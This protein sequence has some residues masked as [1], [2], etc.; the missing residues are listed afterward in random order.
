M[1]R[2]RK[3][4]IFVDLSCEHCTSTFS[5]KY[6][7]RF[8][9][10]CSVKC[11]QSSPV[12]KSLMK[13]SQLKTYREKYGVDH[14]MQSS[15]VVDNFKRSMKQKYGVEH[16][17]QD[18]TF[19]EKSKHTTEQRHG[20]SNYRNTEQMKQT[21]L[22]KYGVD[23]YV[24]TDEYKD[25][26]K[27]TCLK[28][29]GRPHA[30]QSTNFKLEHVKTMFEKILSHDRF[31]NFTPMF[32]QDEYFGILKDAS[33]VKY[34]FKCNRCNN[35]DAYN[36]NNGNPLHCVN[37]DKNNMSYFQKEVY[38]YVKSL[39]GPNVLV[40]TNN[41]TLLK[42]QELDIYIPSLNIAIECDGLYWHSEVMGAKNRVYHYNKTIH[43]ESKGVSLIHVFEN[44]WHQ[45]NEVIKSVL[46]NILGKPSFKIYA[47]NCEVKLITSNKIVES[48]L[49]NNHVQ[50]TAV[51][52][53]KIGLYHDSQLI[54]VM[55]FGKSRFDKNYEWEMVRFCNL[56]N[57]SIVGGAS[58]MFNFFIKNYNPKSI[59]S[60]NDRRYFTGKIYSKL[61]FEFVENTNPNYWYV[62]DS[63]KTLKNRMNFQKHKLKH[64]LPTFDSTLTEWE[65]MKNH[66][67]DRI[68]DCGNG[69]WKY[70]S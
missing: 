12:V 2:P 37:C 28:K 64:I 67:Y 30:S 59:V 25:K 19:A 24:K 60:Y 20:D 17:L 32:K 23:N 5:V 69:K 3:N 54:S 21:C 66:G 16:A 52:S 6:A 61:G 42:P 63:Y 13:D 53:V 4:P 62:I 39:V 9:R 68:W 47:R 40:E 33:I 26:Y 11:S 58:K 1:A 35:V 43:C 14:P 57:F 34:R 56:L 18:S 8:Q 49:N 31:V 51:S 46:N 38:D 70:V 55:T 65:N 50:S 48:F 22:E 27:S 36:L 7:K 44:D 15:N 45:K 29:Y 41:K 10:F